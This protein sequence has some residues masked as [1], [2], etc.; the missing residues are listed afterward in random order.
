MAIILITSD[1][2]GNT[3]LLLSIIKKEKPDFF[4]HLGDLEDFR[5]RVEKELGVPRTPCVFI[6]GN[7]DSKS[8]GD[9]KDNAV[10]RYGGHK[11]Y[12]CHGHYEH[13]NYGKDNLVLSAAEKECDI[14]LYG[15]THVPHDEFI[16]VPFGGPLVHVINPG[17]VARPR[18]GS[19]KS[20]VIMRVKESGAYEVE[21]KNPEVEASDSST[22]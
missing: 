3:E 21:F 7:C 14:A 1:S 15:H 20:Y 19:S 5:S 2:H 10:F 22:I 17:S 8:C 13:V 6:R 4:I 18:G 16:Q 11:F 12:C 9:L